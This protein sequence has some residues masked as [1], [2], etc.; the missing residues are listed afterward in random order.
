MIIV[1]I[2]FRWRQ[3]WKTGKKSG[4]GSGGVWIYS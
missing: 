1:D 3:V 2:K 4:D